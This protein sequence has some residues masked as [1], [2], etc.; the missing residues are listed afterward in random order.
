MDFRTKISISPLESKI[1]LSANSLLIGSCFAQEIG[2]K[3]NDYFLNFYINP[4]GICY[5]PA[6]ILK[7]LSLISSNTKIE[8]TELL[9][10]GQDYCSFDFHGSFNADTPD[11]C[12]RNMNESINGGHQFLST[13]D[14]LIISFGTSFVYETIDSGQIVNNCHKM[15]Q[16][17][18]KRYH[19]MP[20]AFINDYL[21][22]F[23]SLHNN[24]PDLNIILTVSPIRHL[25]DAP[26]EN[27]QSKASLIL[28][29][30]LLCEKLSYVHY[31][32]SY[33][34]M[35]DELRDYRFYQKDMIHPSDLA[36]DYI[37]QRFSDTCLEDDCK[38][39]FNHLDKIYKRLGHKHQT[40]DPAIISSFQQETESQI[41]ALQS[42]Y[43]YL[44]ISLL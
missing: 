34:I 14:F 17:M 19:L 40:N 10:N 16:S 18:F 11:T 29:C 8:A 42:D 31:F 9:K 43:P 15:P 38:A 12:L 4:C 44:S 28:L 37:W 21:S 22:C 26:V 25:R 24:R 13:A 6:A 5:N 20:S 1:G 3:F 36:V 7:A 27:S 41:A 32:P 30:K 23:E 39:Y 2:Q 35:I 33:E